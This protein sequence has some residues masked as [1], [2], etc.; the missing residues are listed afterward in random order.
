MTYY[1]YEISDR[2]VN[3]CVLAGDVS[4]TVDKKMHSIRLQ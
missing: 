1:E 4:S 2:N 3:K